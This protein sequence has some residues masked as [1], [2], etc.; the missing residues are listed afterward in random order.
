MAAIAYVMAAIS[1]VMAAI[2]YAIDEQ[3]QVTGT[4]KKVLIA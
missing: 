3:K 4:N 2:S 1:Y